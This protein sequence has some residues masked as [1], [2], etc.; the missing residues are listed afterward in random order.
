[1]D[2]QRFVRKPFYVDAIRITA[3]NQAEVATWCGGEIQT[4]EKLPAPVQFIKLDV[5]QAQNERQTRA[6]VGDWILQT[7]G[8]FRIYVHRAFLNAFDP[9]R[10]AQ[11]V[12]L[13][14]VGCYLFKRRMEQLNLPLEER[15]ALSD[16]CVVD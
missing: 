15:D 1:M 9:D 12:A 5:K 8:N 13:E 11:E 16:R 6:Y 10:P 2:T 14:R 7:N 4:Q 3:D